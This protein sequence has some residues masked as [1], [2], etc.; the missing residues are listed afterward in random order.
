MCDSGME[1]RNLTANLMLLCSH[2]PSIAEVCRRLGLNRQQFNKYLSGQSRPS[3]HNMRLI[4]DFFGVSESEVL[5]EPGRFEELVALRRNPLD[6]GW[7]DEPLRHIENLYKIS[8]PLDR[9]V[10]YYFR[11]FYSFGY[12]G[13][14]IRSFCAIHEKEGKYYWK[15]LEVMSARAT[16]NPRTISKYV[17][18]ALLIADRIFIFEY[19][20]LRRNSLTQVTL[21]PSYHTRVDQLIG[22]QTGGPVRRGRKPGASRVVLEYL[23][24]RV[25]LREALSQS[26]L[27][28]ASDPRINAGIRDLIRNEIPEGS[29]V[30]EV[31]EP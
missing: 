15:N 5:L 19:E 31:E 7:L 21:Y 23:G 10:G 6:R 2:Y 1:D 24:P 22:V 28:D 18:T 30:L 11:Y 12:P 25:N 20:S 13:K 26:D 29:Y 17:G 9:Y 8:R 16:G 3:R 27:F 4:C 14:I